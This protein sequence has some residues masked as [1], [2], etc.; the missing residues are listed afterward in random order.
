MFT[1]FKKII[2]P[3]QLWL[4]GTGR[5]VGCGK[6]LSKIKNIKSLSKENKLISCACSRQYVYNI[7]KKTYRRALLSEAK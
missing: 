2:E 6:E 1:R 3:M 7:A 4:L 5:C